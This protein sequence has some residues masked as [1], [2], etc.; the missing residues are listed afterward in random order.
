MKPIIVDMKDMSDTTEV[1]ESRPNP[2]LVY[3]IYLLLLIC[4]VGIVWTAFSDIDIVVKSNGIFRNDENS[5]EVS[6]SV[7]GKVEKC[8]ISEGQLVE[9]GEVLFT[10]DGEELEET[11]QNYQDMLDDVNERIEILK[12]YEK[13]LTGDTESLE[14]LSDNKYY[15]EFKNKKKLLDLSIDNSGSN[16][17]SQEKQY[18]TEKSS[19]QNSMNQYEVQLAK[20]EQVKSCIQTRANVFGTE[21]SYYKSIVDSYVAN[22]NVTGV[23]Y[24]NQIAE[25]EKSKESLIEQKKS[26]KKGKKDETNDE[27]KQRETNLQELEKNIETVNGN[28]ESAKSEKTQALNNLEL[29]QI[30][31]VEQQIESVKETLLSLKSNETTIQAQIDTLKEA[32]SENTEEMNLLTEQGNVANELITYEN[33]KTEYENSLKQYSLQNGKV[34]VTAAD[35]GYVSLTQEIKEGTYIQQGSVICE[36]FPESQGGYYADIYVDNADIAKLKEGQE[37]KFEIAAYPSSEYGYVIG[38]IETIAQDIKV[39]QNSGSAYY[40]VKVRC[41]KTT[42][43]NKNGKSGSIKNGMAC[44]AKIVVD[45]QQVL[46][47]LLEKINLV[48]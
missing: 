11:I 3:F 13:S 5:F 41:E 47:Y 28:I 15:T 40:P 4:I 36:I 39:D 34:T 30:T 25:Y 21:D 38:T 12:A 48:D 2:F 43:S 26:L 29:Q 16:E 23:Q 19:I 22:Y 31:S 1:Y 45:E 46:R 27:K 33:K 18:E 9:K 44:Q 7:S 32:Q 42:L 35:T 17:K 14:S 24:D 37:V 6:S 10:L 20:L 8:N